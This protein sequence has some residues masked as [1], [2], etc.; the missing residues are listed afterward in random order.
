MKASFANGGRKL[1]SWKSNVENLL[2][3]RKCKM[4]YDR[5]PVCT[6]KCVCT[7][8]T[9]EVNTTFMCIVDHHYNFINPM[10]G[11]VFTLS[12]YTHT[13]FC[14]SAYETFSLEMKFLFAWFYVSELPAALSLSVSARIN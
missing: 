8:Q 5:M 1:T 3:S 7:P 14:G 12:K 2:T 4:Q 6:R 9:T 13:K 10:V 11:S